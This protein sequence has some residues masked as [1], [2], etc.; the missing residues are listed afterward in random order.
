MR[1]KLSFKRPF[2]V[3]KQK[4]KNFK[5]ACL[6]SFK[7]L[8]NSESVLL[9]YTM[10]ETFGSFDMKWIFEIWALQFINV[11]KFFYLTL[12]VCNNVEQVYGFCLE[13]HF[14][15]RHNYMKA[16]IVLT[17]KEL[18]L[19]IIALIIRNNEK[20]VGTEENKYF[21][22]NGKIKLIV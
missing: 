5:Y 4:N 18:R 10:L 21:H 17:D 12:T 22:S 11:K 15:F 8:V 7:V 14:Y 19:S 9:S 1:N 16:V 3:L 13:I 6:I 2:P 20:K